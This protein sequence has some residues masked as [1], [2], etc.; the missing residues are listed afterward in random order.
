M[1]LEV[2]R[3]CFIIQCILQ[4]ENVRSKKAVF[5]ALSPMFTCKTLLLALC[6]SDEIICIER[7]TL[8]N[9]YDEGFSKYS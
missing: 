7:S 1:V 4:L 6:F 9:C 8:L 2:I 5:T 3:Q